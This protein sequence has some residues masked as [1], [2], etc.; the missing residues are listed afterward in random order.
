VPHELSFVDNINQQL[1]GNLYSKMKSN[2]IKSN[3]ILIIDNI[4]ILSSIYKYG[5]VTYIGG[6]FG[7]GIH[8][9][10]EAAVFNI[11]VIFGP[12]YQRFKEAR[13]L[14]KINGARSIR[15]YQELVFTFDFF[16]K[17]KNNIG[18]KYIIKNSGATNIIVQ[19]I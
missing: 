13:E 9:I 16:L 17:K 15:N 3:N 10:L 4:G 1:E 14:I 7:K 19:H 11:P 8:N 2:K 18:N 6:G 5:D 12:K